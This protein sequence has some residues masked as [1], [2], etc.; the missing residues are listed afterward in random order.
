MITKEQYEMAVLEIKARLVKVRILKEEQDLFILNNLLDES[1]GEEVNL[2]CDYVKKLDDT[3]EELCELLYDLHYKY[4]SQF[5]KP[6]P[7]SILG[8]R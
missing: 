3:E 1:K 6:V 5:A 2:A 8:S 7:T 4:R